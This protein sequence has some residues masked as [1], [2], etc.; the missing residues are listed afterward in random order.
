MYE[1]AGSPTG[2]APL[3]KIIELDP[4]NETNFYY[5]GLTYF[6]SQQYDRAVAAFQQSLAIKPDFPHAWYQ[7]GS[8]YFNAK[9]YKEAAEAYKKYVEARP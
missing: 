6:K 9:K 1:A 8:S 5:L 2:V 4:K 3:L 7:I